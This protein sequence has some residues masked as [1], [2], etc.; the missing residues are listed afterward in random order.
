[1]NYY[2]DT[3]LLVSSL[4]REAATGRAQAW[5]RQHVSA[6]F[7]ISDW[8]VAEFASAL[9]IKLRTGEISLEKRAEIAAMFTRSRD[10]FVE[11]AVERAHFQSAAKYVERHEPGLRTGDALHLAI[12]SAEGAALVTLDKKLAAAGLALGVETISV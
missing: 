3:S 9:S 6:T 8:V 10:T 5:L 4:A 2:L 11:L 1:M 7:F 12:A